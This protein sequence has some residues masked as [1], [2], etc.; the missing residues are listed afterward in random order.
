M[1]VC[2]A[3]GKLSRRRTHTHTYLTTRSKLS[4]GK[5]RCS[6]SPNTSS[7]STALA[8]GPAAPPDGRRSPCSV[9]P[10]RTSRSMP[11][12]PPSVWFVGVSAWS[13]V[14]FVVRFVQSSLQAGLIHF[15]QSIYPSTYSRPGPPRRSPPAAPA[16]RTRPAPRRRGTRA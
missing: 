12:A 7:T 3:D 4:G 13:V 6:S 16:G 15:S 11:P 2:G 14:G 5:G 10:H 1:T 9:T 8:A